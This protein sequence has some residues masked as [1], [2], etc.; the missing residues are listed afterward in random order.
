MDQDGRV[1]YRR[2]ALGA[3]IAAG[4]AWCGWASAFAAG[5]RAG[6]SVWVVSLAGVVVADLVISW[7]PGHH[8]VS[9]LTP[10][11]DIGAAEPLRRTSPPPEAVGYSW[12]ALWPWVAMVVVV[13]VW[14][15]LGI[16]TG[17]H[18]PHLTLS[19]LTLAFRG[20]RA[21]TLTVWIALG[22]GFALVR[23]R[24]RADRGVDRGQLSDRR[25]GVGV[26]RSIRNTGSVRRPGAGSG[27]GSLVVAPVIALG[28]LGAV[29]GSAGSGFAGHGFAGSGYGARIGGSGFG[30]LVALLLGDSRA[31]GVG[32]W[33]GVV[34]C[35]LLV[36]LAARRL[37][38]GIATF[39]TVL[40]LVTGPP[41]AR[42]V[43]VGAWVYA[44]WHL[45]AH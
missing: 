35:G 30:V 11:S 9:P 23:R 39:E 19:A 1:R 40:R 3:L 4:L 6:Q 12:A 33:I 14:E 7:V 36:E 31:V 5:T 8:G 38:A 37:R 21:A 22:I 25:L 15:I 43:A 44:G 16:D 42:I 10:G 41:V 18:Q 13:V 32:F 26:A 29:V 24:V 17:P 27:S 28:A 45:F 20:M 34:V 2:A